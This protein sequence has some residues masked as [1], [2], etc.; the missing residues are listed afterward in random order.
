MKHYVFVVVF[1]QKDFSRQSRS[2]IV[3]LFVPKDQKYTCNSQITISFAGMMMVIE[4]II[5]SGH[6][7]L[8]RSIVDSRKLM[9]E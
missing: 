1:H 5:H 4:L 8:K 3:L 6:V 2:F 7:N 9:N